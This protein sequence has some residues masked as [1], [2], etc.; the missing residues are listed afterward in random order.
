MEFAET[1][2]KHL[3][4]PRTRDPQPLDSE[5]YNVHS[6][7]SAQ[8]RYGAAFLLQLRQG[9][10]ATRSLGSWL[11][12]PRHQSL[13]VRRSSHQRNIGYWTTLNSVQRHLVVNGS[14]ICPHGMAAGGAMPCRPWLPHPDY[15]L[16]RQF[17]QQG[18]RSN[19]QGLELYS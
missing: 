19:G 17:I 7:F 2:R 13:E 15:H 1:L 4:H 3:N 18:A 16:D 9:Q 12:P 8:E 5:R 14:G 11:G 6:I 10:C